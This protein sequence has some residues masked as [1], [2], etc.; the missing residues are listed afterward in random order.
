MTPS[1]D[2]RPKLASRFESD[3]QGEQ[4]PDATEVV[5]A[6]IRPEKSVPDAPDTRRAHPTSEESPIR[7][8]KNIDSLRE[9]KTPGK[10]MTHPESFRSGDVKAQGAPSERVHVP[11]KI[12]EAA[13]ALRV[14][15]K[16]APPDSDPPTPE[17]ARP[18]PLKGVGKAQKEKNAISFASPPL[19]AQSVKA[20]FKERAGVSPVAKPVKPTPAAPA[21]LT[22]AMTKTDIRPLA[23]K[24]APQ[25]MEPASPATGQ[26]TPEQRTIKITIGR[27]DVRAVLPPPA[28]P[29]KEARPKRSSPQIT[30]HDYLQKQRGGSR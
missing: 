1:Q 28:T 3:D 13:P 4:P 30:L 10:T 19:E 7:Q 15:S 21:A 17:N 24:D 5:E 27:I 20:A 16:V 12:T 14:A 11:A 25:W 26:E 18:R 23:V 9:Q 6:V 22:P 29:A 2:I 8:T